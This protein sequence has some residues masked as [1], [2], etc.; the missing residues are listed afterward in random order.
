VITIEPNVIVGL[1]AGPGGVVNEKEVT[2]DT[3]VFRAASVLLTGIAFVRFYRP[4][5]RTLEQA[6]FLQSVNPA[7]AQTLQNR[8]PH[9]CPEGMV[10]KLNKAQRDKLNANHVEPTT[11][12]MEGGFGTL[13]SK[14]KVAPTMSTSK[15]STLVQAK[16]NKTREWLLSLPF[17]TVER[18]YVIACKIAKEQHKLRMVHKK[19]LEAARSQRMFEVHAPSILYSSSILIPRLR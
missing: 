17:E 15:A 13:D 12:K 9:I 2:H 6:K 7:L 19:D 10:G 1:D 14:F 16:L 18:L 8:Q 11:D 4:D 5:H 3:P